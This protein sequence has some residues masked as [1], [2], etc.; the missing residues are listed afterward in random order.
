MSFRSHALCERFIN[1]MM[2][3]AEPLSPEQAIDE[4]KSEGYYPEKETVDH[5]LAHLARARWEVLGSYI[6]NEYETPDSER[7]GWGG[8]LI[9]TRQGQI[10]KWQAMFVI[11]IDYV[12]SEK[13]VRQADKIRKLKDA[14]ILPYAIHGRRFINGAWNDI[15]LRFE[16]YRS[17]CDAW[18][19]LELD[20]H[21][22]EMEF[23]DNVGGN[24]VPSPIQR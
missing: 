6:A 21:H 13:R 5:V 10:E 14:D 12:E 23:I 20:H 2:D 22:V 4:A 3:M 17:A 15:Q 8:E 7:T 19:A 1:M 18:Y 24:T 9:S 16:D 11:D